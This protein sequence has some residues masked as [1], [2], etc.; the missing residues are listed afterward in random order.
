MFQKLKN[1]A[2][3][4]ALVAGSMVFVSTSAEAQD[5]RWRD[6]GDDTAIVAI[7]A[8]VIGL[9]LGAALS[10][11][12][13][14]RRY[15][16]DDGYYYPRGGDY[17]YN[18]YPQYDYRYRDN[19]RNW[20]D[21]NRGWGNNYRNDRRWRG[22]RNERRWRDRDDRGDRSRRDYNRDNGREYRRGW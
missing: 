22:E 2:L 20:R 19:G 3:M 15:Y 14:D 17:Y 6:N 4:A 1:S 12:N 5:R 7:G 16:R 21:N 10:S 9:A 13:K 18:G 8:G 11:G